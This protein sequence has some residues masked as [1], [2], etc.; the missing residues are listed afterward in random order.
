MP[1]YSLITV[2][3]DVERFA[4]EFLTRLC[5]EPDMSVEEA[6]RLALEAIKKPPTVPIRRWSDISGG[7]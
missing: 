6:R 3:L 1:D 4:I 7:P 2:Q 5:R